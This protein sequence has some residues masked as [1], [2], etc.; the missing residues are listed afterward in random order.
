MAID[1]PD[2]LDNTNVKINGAHLAGYSDSN[3]RSLE[4]TIGKTPIIPRVVCER[5]PGI[6]YFIINDNIGL[7]KLDQNSFA[8][9]TQLYYLYV[10]KNQISSI[11]SRTFFNNLSVKRICLSHFTVST[12]PVD[13]FSKNT[14]LDF[15]EIGEMNNLIDLPANIFKNL[16]NLVY[17]RIFKA[18]IKVWRPEWTKNLPNALQIS[19]FSSFTV[20]EVPLNAINSPNLKFLF[21]DQNNMKFIDSRSVGNVTSLQSLHIMNQP[22]EGIDFELI[23]NAKSLTTLMAENMACINQNFYNFDKNRDAYM[24]IL[25]PCFDGYD[26]RSLSKFFFNKKKRFILLKMN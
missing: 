11:D 13:L 25:K 9:C 12:L 10:Y 18:K 2:G 24:K 6:W 23:D 4:I 17:L 3:I 7:K 22:V 20:P 5:F 1:N 19:I 15:V 26:K 14:L 16:I 8:K 21:I